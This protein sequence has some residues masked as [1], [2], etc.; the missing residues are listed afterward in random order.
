MSKQ[1]VDQA[2]KRRREVE[3]ALNQTIEDTIRRHGPTNA[4]AWTGVTVGAFLLNL[5][6]LVLVTG[7]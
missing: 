7:G 3:E 2:K 1:Q 5:G 6:L 4:L